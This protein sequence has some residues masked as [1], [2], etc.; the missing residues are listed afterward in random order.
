MIK[1][2]YQNFYKRCKIGKDTTVGEFVD[3]AGRV[4]ARC[5]I[6]SFVFIPE[7]VVIED[8]C[9]I[10]PMAV[11]GNDK[12]PPST[13]REIT[14]VREGAKIGMGAVILPG[15]EIGKGAMIGAGAVVTKDVESYGIVVGN[16]AKQIKSN[17]PLGYENCIQCGQC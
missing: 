8:D 17:C 9:F 15:I 6:Q 7:G 10:G 5:K 14:I 1:R 11:F 2:K 16:P 4:G 13:K 12:N 3:I